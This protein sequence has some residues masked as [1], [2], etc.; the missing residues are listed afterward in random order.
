M[1]KYA[2]IELLDY[3]IATCLILGRAAAVV[4]R[5]STKQQH[6]V[7]RLRFICNIHPYNCTLASNSEKKGNKIQQRFAQNDVK[8]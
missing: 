4:A 3:K 7:S 8:I 6:T 1:I 5:L 2:F